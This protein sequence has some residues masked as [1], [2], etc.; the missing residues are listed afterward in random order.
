MPGRRG[1]LEKRIASPPVLRG[2]VHGVE[3]VRR[4]GVRG[5]PRGEDARTRFRDRVSRGRIST[6]VVAAE[7]GIEVN[8]RL[9]T[10]SAA[11]R[12]WPR[13]PSLS[14]LP[15]TLKSDFFSTDSFIDC[16]TGGVA[17]KAGGLFKP[18]FGLS[19]LLHTQF[20]LESVATQGFFCLVWGCSA[21]DA[22]TQRSARDEFR[23]ER[24]KCEP[25]RRCRKRENAPLKPK[26]GL[27]GPRPVVLLKP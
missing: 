14:S 26:S 4:N 2:N 16:R 17:D 19:G 24:T 27:N 6:C 13:Q 21:S 1:L 15:T 12:S 5:R 18:D 8:P 10:K 22:E 3:A 20:Q 25:G 7:R 11:T 9:A 23:M